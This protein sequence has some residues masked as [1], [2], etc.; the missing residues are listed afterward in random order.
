MTKKAK[1]NVTYFGAFK[2][3]LK[4]MSNKYSTKTSTKATKNNNNNNNRTSLA[5]KL[6]KMFYLL[7]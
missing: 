6:W 3:Q 1:Y 7:F 4:L 2:Q 5:I